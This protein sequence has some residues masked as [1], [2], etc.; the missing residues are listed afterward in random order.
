MT[1]NDWQSVLSRINDQHKKKTNNAFALMAQA[2]AQNKPQPEVPAKATKK[3]KF[4]APNQAT[5]AKPTVAD[6]YTNS[7]TANNSSLANARV[8]PTAATVTATTA[9]Q[10]TTASRVTAAKNTAQGSFASELEQFTNAQTFQELAGKARANNAKHNNAGKTTSAKDSGKYQKVVATGNNPFASLLQNSKTSNKNSTTTNQATTRIASNPTVTNGNKNSTTTSYPDHDQH[11][12]FARAFHQN[13]YAGMDYEYEGLTNSNNPFSQLLN[14]TNKSPTTVVK[15]PSQY[16][17]QASGP[18]NRSNPFPTSNSSNL[19][20]AQQLASVTTVAHGAQASNATATGQQDDLRAT[21]NPVATTT[22]TDATSNVATSKSN[23]TRKQQAI[24]ERQHQAD[25]EFYKDSSLQEELSDYALPGSSRLAQLNQAYWSQVGY[26]DAPATKLVA[27]YLVK[28]KPTRAQQQAQAWQQNKLFQATATQAPRQSLAQLRKKTPYLASVLESFSIAGTEVVLP[29]EAEKH[30]LLDLRRTVTK[31]SLKLTGDW[32]Q[33]LLTSCQVASGWQLF[34]AIQQ[35]ATSKFNQQLAT[36]SD[37]NAVSET[38]ETSNANNANNANQVDNSNTS[39]SSNANETSETNNNNDNTTGAS[40]VAPQDLA[41]DT[42]QPDVLLACLNGSLESQAVTAY[43][44][45]RLPQLQQQFSNYNS[46][47]TKFLS[48]LVSSTFCLLKES[49]QRLELIPEQID[50]NQDLPV[51]QYI[52]DIA[53]LLEQHQVVVIAGETGSGKTTQLP[54]LCLELGL[55]QTGLIGHTQPRRIAATSVAKRIAQELHS[56]LGQLV[57]YKIRFNDHLSPYSHIKLMTDGILLA[58]LQ[59]DPYLEQYSCLIIDE[60]HERSLNNDFIL[61]YLK[62]ILKQRR[63][64]KII[65]TSATIEVERFAKHFNNCPILQVSGRTFPVE[66]R[67]RPLTLDSFSSYHSDP[68]SQAQVEQGSRGVSGSRDSTPLNLNEKF[69]SILY[70]ATHQSANSQVSNTNF[71]VTTANTL[72]DAPSDSSVHSDSNSIALAHEFEASKQPN[73][74]TQLDHVVHGNNGDNAQDF[75]ELDQLEDLEAIY[76]KLNLLNNNISSNFDLDNFE[77]AINL[78]TTGS[79]GVN[80]A[81]TA[82]TTLDMARDLQQTKHN[83]HHNHSLEPVSPEQA[84]VTK[85]RGSNA[86]NSWF[87]SGPVDPIYG[88]PTTNPYLAEQNDTSRYQRAVISAQNRDQ[89]ALAT[90]QVTTSNANLNTTFTS[91]SSDN[92]QP[93]NHVAAATGN[94]S[95]QQNKASL[96]TITSNN[97]R[98]QTSTNKPATSFKEQLHQATGISAT[99]HDSFYQEASKASNYHL[100]TTEDVAQLEQEGYLTQTNHHLV[101]NQAVETNSDVKALQRYRNYT[102]KDQDS[103]ELAQGVI[104]A[105]EELFS[106]GHGDIL[107]FLSGEREIHDVAAELTNH[108]TRVNRRYP[109]LRILPLYSRLAS[110]EQQLIFQPDGNLRVI[111]ATNIAE[112]SLTVPGIKYVIDAGT[113]RISRY[114]QRTQV[115]GLPIEAIS[116]ASANQRKGRCGRT[117]PGICIRLYSE[118]DF[119]SR[120]EYTDPEITRTNLSAVILKML[121]LNLPNI[122]QFPFLDAPNI[123]NIR[124]GITLLKQLQALTTTTD[125]DGQERTVITNLGKQLSQLP[126]DPRLGRMIIA[127]SDLGCLNEMLAIASGLTIVDVRERPTGKE[128]Q[129]SQMHAEYRD[130]DSDYA[131]ILNL[132]NYL[133]EHKEMSNNQLRKLCKRRFLNYLR[134]REWQDL[135][136]QLKLAA[137]SLKLKFNQV[138]AAYSE[139]HKAMIPGLL[140]H[141]AQLDSAQQYQFKGAN[142]RTFKFFP[143]AAVTKQRFSWVIASEIVHLSQTYAL[144]GAKILSEWVEDFA[145]HLVRSSYHSPHFNKNRGEVVALEDLYL[146]GLKIASNKITSYSSIDP[147]VSRQI[148]IRSALVEQNWQAPFDFFKHNNHVIST[149]RKL[150]EQQRKIG[151]YLTEDDLY[152]FYAS[153]IPANINNV[154][155]FKNWYH[156]AQHQQEKLLFLDLER[157]QQTAELAQD[158]PTELVDGNYK[159]QLNYIFDPKRDDDGVILLIPIAVLQHLDPRRYTWHIANY[160]QELIEELIRGLPKN[161]RKQLIPAPEYARAFMQRVPDL[162]TNPSN[163]QILSLYQSLSA[164]FRSI[165]GVVIDT[166]HWIDALANLAPHLRMHFKVVDFE[167]NELA[168]S[169]NLQQLQESLRFTAQELID[170]QQR[171]QDAQAKVYTDWSFGKVGVKETTKLHGMILD[172]YVTL[173]PAKLLKLDHQGDVNQT[174]SSQLVANQNAWGNSSTTT[175]KATTNSSNKTSPAVDLHCYI[176][177]QLRGVVVKYVATPVEQEHYLRLGLLELL[178]LNSADTISYSLSKINAKASISRL[179][180]GDVNALLYQLL[181]MSG[182]TIIDANLG[183]AHEQALKQQGYA[184]N[185]ETLARGDLLWTY[186]TYEYLQDKLRGNLYSTANEIFNLVA[187][188]LE[189]TQSLRRDLKKHNSFA[190]A[191][192]CQDIANQVTLFTSEQFFTQASLEQLHQV[193]R[194]LKALSYRLE[195]LNSNAQHDLRRMQEVSDLEKD[196]ASLEATWPEYRDRKQLQLLFTMLQELRVSLFAQVIGCKMTVSTKRIQSYIEQLKESRY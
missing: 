67:Y 74:T 4:F 100:L 110:H 183:S 124:N 56:D 97:N 123:A 176:K 99:A 91:S 160:R 87:T 54:K 101:A 158:F 168:T 66:V 108:F 165:N 15:S 182:L 94:Q 127:A 53:S 35:D 119:N 154:A 144:R 189:Q 175:A 133:Q 129:A 36:L 117:S 161:L 104:A 114:N 10:A 58:E 156:K 174:A 48:Q 28:G 139:I 55:S 1:N 81:A 135:Y 12:E 172:N 25:Q 111:L 26:K 85:N 149:L 173:Y 116:Q 70:D 6:N 21:V 126:L 125:H 78:E 68:T 137:I 191:M 32:W 102:D 96:Q 105:C 86:T 71:T 57:G 46:H 69:A 177:Q 73:A 143:G 23:I 188:I 122:E 134:V 13:P 61:G 11:G 107:V 187:Q 131:T 30:W 80:G 40:Q 150:E 39:N 186:V 153:L 178:L 76:A 128:M 109:G 167:G 52:D 16:G 140:D 184:V 192:S 92:S 84:A 185:D 106:E 22:E 121:S 132:W 130:K 44:N 33:Q 118:Q 63:D 77:S 14:G 49:K 82:T 98:K 3:Q 34:Q 113:A 138:P 162:A 152:D 41:S 159:L 181:R 93:S 72:T 166:Q 95:L 195:K 147:V 169:D 145:Q 31:H 83:A 19:N 148:F 64:I 38:N 155:S 190:T 120:P 24:L 146:F 112:T 75:E 9:P 2:V 47:F 5:V 62:V 103:L 171:R 50:Y 88:L 42:D 17:N 141:I 194:Y 157:L 60:A 142:G 79:S 180:Q 136:N 196:Y 115:Q 90:S 89:K 179:Y 151:N 51:A 193:P 45:D 59:N 20:Q 8:T 164:T 7:T 27:N 65:I 170:K 43:L 163:N 18:A 29:L 37:A